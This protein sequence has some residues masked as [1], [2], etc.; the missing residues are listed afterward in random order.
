MRREAALP[1]AFQWLAGKVSYVQQ[2][3]ETE[4]SASC[5]ACGGTVHEDGSWPDRLR[6]FDRPEHSLAWCRRCNYMRFADQDTKPVDPALAE[7]WRLEQIQREE[8]RKKSA[9][10]ALDLLRQE[11]RWV[12]YHETM[13]ERGI[14]WWE[15]RGIPRAYQ[16]VWQLGWRDDLAVFVDSDW[17]LLEAA[18]IPVFDLAGNVLNVKNRIIQPPEGVPKYR[19]ELSGHTAPL[20]LCNPGEPL[21]GHVIAVEGEIKAAVVWTKLQDAHA[22]VVGLPGTSPPRESLG[23]LSQAKRI[24]LVMD[25]GSEEEAARLAQTLGRDRTRILVCVEKIDDAILRNQMGKAEV[26]RWLKQANGGRKGR[27]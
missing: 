8:A 26:V 27:Q 6:I 10:R 5:P 7:R 11:Q 20:F 16:Y 25:P 17:R 13:P 3:S 18:T 22:Q 4:Y 24:T 14:L 2:V 19:Y 9:E 15:T 12:R 1:P 21:D 23:V